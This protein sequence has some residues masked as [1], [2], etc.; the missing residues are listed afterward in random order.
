MGFAALYPSYAIVVLQT[1]H[2]AA[3]PCSGCHLGSSVV[4]E[5]AKAIL[6]PG[7]LR[8]SYSFGG[9]VSDNRADGDS[10]VAKPDAD[11]FIDWN[12]SR[13]HGGIAQ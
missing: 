3:S 5:D 10:A 2:S 6:D 7:R 4:I 9:K 11:L 8:R 13:R 12:C 1:L